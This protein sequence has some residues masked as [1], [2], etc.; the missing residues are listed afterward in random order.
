MIHTVVNHADN[1]SRAVVRLPNSGY[2]CVLSSRAT[3]L[4]RVVEVPLV[5]EVRVVGEEL[6]RLSSLDEGGE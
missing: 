1:D 2:V 3:A 4:S 5:I 6:S